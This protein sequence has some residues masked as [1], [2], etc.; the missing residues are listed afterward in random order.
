MFTQQSIGIF[1]SGVGGLTVFHAIR[2]AF[3]HENLVYFGDT[4]R[5]PYGPKSKRTVI[6]YSIQNTRFLI[7]QNVKII[8]VACNTSSAVAIDII[9]EIT[10]IPVIGVIIP[11]A[12]AAVKATRNMK[13]GVIGTYGTIRS[14]AYTQAILSLMPDAQIFSHPC[15]LFV[16]L[17]EEGWEDHPVT[18]QVAE[19]YLEPLKNEGIDTLVLGCT[20]YPILKKTIQKVVGPNIKLVDSAD[21]IIPHLKQDLPI[22]NDSGTG[23]DSF[24]VSD[25][26]AQ[27][28]SIAKGILER[29]PDLVKMVKLGESWFVENK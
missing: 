22:A 3:P 16:P 29:K 9:K 7:Q 15:P 26:E 8:V 12:E 6:D 25:N 4:A 11:G 1:D 19:H 17:A 23:K 10:D 24:F 20:H 5:V 2:T 14:N 28:I 27:F 18:Y 13:I 21:A